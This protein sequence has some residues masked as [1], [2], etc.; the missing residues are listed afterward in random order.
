M[1]G[2]D[3][4]TSCHGRACTP[5]SP[6]RAPSLTLD[7]VRASTCCGERK[8]AAVAAQVQHAGA[9][10]Q[11]RQERAAVALVCECKYNHSSRARSHQHS[12]CQVWH[13]GGRAAR[14]GALNSCKAKVATQALCGCQAM[15]MMCSAG[16]AFKSRCSVM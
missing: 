11:R 6:Q 8:G 13:E 2:L 5:T 7:A 1:H 15:A 10:A 12:P 16:R 4:C 3:L 14:L 9:L